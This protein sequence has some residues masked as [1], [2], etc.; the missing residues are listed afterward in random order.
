MYKLFSNRLKFVIA[1]AMISLVTFS[2][3]DFLQIEPTS[4][5]SDK[6]LWN[7][8]DNADLFLNDIYSGLPGPF[9]THDPKENWS[10]NSM[11]AHSWGFSTTTIAKAAYTSENAPNEWGHYSN[12]RKTNLFISK[13]NESSLSEDWKKQRLGE[14]RFLRAYYYMLLWTHYGGV[15]IITDVLNQQEQGEEIFKARN[16]AEETYQ[17]IVTELGEIVNNLP[18]EAEEGR[19]TRGS[20]LTLKGWCELYW[21]SPLYNENNE[22]S[23]WEEAASTYKRVM[24]LGVYE[25]FP[26][27]NGQF[28]EDNNFNSETI[29]AKTYVGGTG[30][31][32]SR[33][34]L[35]GVWKVDGNQYAWSGVDPTQELVDSYYMSNGLSID[36]PESGYDPQNPYEDRSERFYQSIIYDGSEWLGHEIIMKQGV[37]SDNATDLGAVNEATNTGYYYRKGLHPE[38]A[39]NGPNQLSSANFIIFR[40]AEVLLG[41]AEAYNEAF[42][43]DLSVYNAINQV[44][45]RVNL[46]PLQNEMN[47]EEM[48]EAIHQERRVELALEGKRYFDLLRLKQ[49]EEKLN[50]HLHA[51]VIEQENGSWIYNVV[52]ATDGSV[53]FHPEKNYVFPIPQ[54]AMDRNQKLEQNPGY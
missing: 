41:Y 31:G 13:V 34:G 25:L 40:Y 32:G 22:Q 50:G 44:R 16:T 21:A 38:Y 5:I 47:R 39:V 24:D 45:D 42:G 14:A 15:P 10:D 29:F 2:C 53:T 12:I 51:M 17:F 7:S 19:V 27:Y 49:A 46:P 11:S 3:S 9:N 52:P 35:Q 8:T 48:R 1:V 37:G 23:R 43:P 18:L 4:Q 36:H 30:L 6:T 26:D 33:E 28:M 20:A 54:N